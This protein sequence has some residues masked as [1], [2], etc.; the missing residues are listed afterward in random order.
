MEDEQKRIQADLAQERMLID[1]ITLIKN[2]MKK[3]A[4]IIERV[5]GLFLVENKE[6]ESDYKI[7]SNYTD[8]S[9]K[10]C[11][12]ETKRVPADEL[13]FLVYGKNIAFEKFKD[14]LGTF[15][16]QL[17]SK[18]PLRSAQSITEQEKKMLEEKYFCEHMSSNFYHDGYSYVDE[19]GNR[20]S[21][22]P[23][24]EKLIEIFIE[25]ENVKIAE[26]TLINK[27]IIYC[28]IYVEK[29]WTFPKKKLDIK[30]I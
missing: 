13:G 7:I 12:N 15:R 23:N 30:N 24:I 26:Y 18:L 29:S 11:N 4:F 1:E 25:D 21:R 5:K 14:V 17:R 19:D 2:S 20:Q 9:V 27:L 6:L 16:T 8:V 3:N 22:H 10:S 28:Y